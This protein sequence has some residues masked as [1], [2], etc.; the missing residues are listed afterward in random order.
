MVNQRVVEIPGDIANT[1]DRIVGQTTGALAPGV[2]KPFRLAFDDLADSWNRALPELVVAQIQFNQ[3]SSPGN[4]PNFWLSHPSR[5]LRSTAT[6]DARH[7]G[8][9]D[10]TTVIPITTNAASSIVAGLWAET[11]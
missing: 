3:I 9:P 2:S 4:P 1:G 11:P 5:R 8:N 10:E 6:H 7:T